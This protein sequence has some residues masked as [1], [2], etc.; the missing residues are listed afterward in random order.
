MKRVEVV[1]GGFFIAEGER[2]LL[3][4]ARY[5][6]FMPDEDE[7]KHF[8]RKNNSQ[9]R[10]NV[11]LF[12]DAAFN[13]YLEYAKTEIG[14]KVLISQHQEGRLRAI[15][16]KDDPAANKERQKAQAQLDGAREAIEKLN[17]LYQDVLTH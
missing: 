2:L 1:T 10:C 3:V 15:E 12:G 5:V 4:I 8:E 14:S 7:N 11:T 6:V 17:T 13:K 9:H 16:G